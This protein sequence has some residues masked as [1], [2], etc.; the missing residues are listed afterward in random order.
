[1][2]RRRYYG[3]HRLGHLG[4]GTMSAEEEAEVR[5][6]AR[7]M[8][9]RRADTE[10]AQVRAEKSKSTFK[11]IAAIGAVAV[12]GVVGFMLVRKAIRKRREEKEAQAGLTTTLAKNETAVKNMQKAV[13]QGTMP[14]PTLG[15]ATAQEAAD[16]LE[17]EMDRAFSTSDSIKTVFFNYIKNGADYLLVRDAFGKRPYSLMGKPAFSWMVSEKDRIGLHEWLQ[18]ELD[19]KTLKEID[20]FIASSGAN[21]M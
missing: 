3:R 14:A 17:N 21:N 15:T 8:E 2:K 6:H 9:R 11:T 7:D 5:E 20:D 16:S 10:M 12:V 18:N 13:K 1:M 19:A 4:E